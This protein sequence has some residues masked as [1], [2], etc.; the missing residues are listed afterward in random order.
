MFVDAEGSRSQSGGP[1]TR[2]PTLG[3]LAKAGHGRT[4]SAMAADPPEL[5]HGSALLRQL[6]GDQC[7]G[8][9]ERLFLPPKRDDAGVTTAGELWKRWLTSSCG[10]G[11]SACPRSMSTGELHWAIDSFWRWRQAEATHDDPFLDYA[12]REDRTLDNRREGRAGVGYR[13]SLEAPTAQ[14]MR[15]VE[16]ALRLWHA[17]TQS[18]V[19]DL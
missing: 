2:C 6:L 5:A 14:T 8:I 15:L 11:I 12:R 13:R 10:G 9:D 4:V 18:T 1:A 7:E 19:V 17:G 3:L 16:R